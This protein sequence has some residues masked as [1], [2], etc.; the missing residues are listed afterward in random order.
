MRYSV[1]YAADNASLTVLKD[2]LVNGEVKEIME[3]FGLGIGN[4]DIYERG[5]WND[6]SF[7]CHRVCHDWL[8]R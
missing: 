7:A 8:E 2:L 3:L 4:R 5:G 1:V 6:A